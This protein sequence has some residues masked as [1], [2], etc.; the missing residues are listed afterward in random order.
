[1]TL[2]GAV[3]QLLLTDQALTFVLL[4]GSW[5]SIQKWTFQRRNSTE[6]SS[7]P[8]L[9]Q[10]AHQTGQDLCCR[11]SRDPLPWASKHFQHPHLSLLW[12]QLREVILSCPVSSR[13][14]GHRTSL[15]QFQSEPSATLPKQ[16]LA[17]KEGLEQKEH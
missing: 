16:Q 7:F 14:Q 2:R 15:Q 1:M 9:P 5:N 3:L 6:S 8:P 10:S 17:E 11:I 4:A 12:R 13:T